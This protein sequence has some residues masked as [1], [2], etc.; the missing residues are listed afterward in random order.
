MAAGTTGNVA[1]AEDAPVG[2]I[3]EPAE[4]LKAVGYAADEIPTHEEFNWTMQ[5][6]GRAS[7]R[8]FATSEDLIAARRAGP[9]AIPE[10]VGIVLPGG[11]YSGSVQPWSVAWAIA[12]DAN[13]T[14]MCCD[15]EYLW[16]TAGAGIAKFIRR[17]LRST[18]AIDLD[19]PAGTFDYPFLA[20]AGGKV[21]VCDDVAG[22]P[23]LQ[24]YNRTDLTL[25]YSLALPAAATVYAIATDG[26]FVGVAAG[27]FLRLY[28]DTGAALALVGS[29]DHTA[30]V[31]SVAM[32]GHFIV[33]GGVTPGGGPP[34]N[35]IRFLDYTPALSDSR[36]RT[37]NPAV[38]KVCFDGEAVGFAG[39]IDGA[40]YTGYFR[41]RLA[42]IRWEEA[43]AAEDCLF[44]DGRLILAK[45]GSI[46]IHDPF[47]GDRID[48][49][50][51]DAG[52]ATNVH[53]LAHDFDGFF[54]LGDATAGG[55]RLRRYH[56]TN[57]PRLY[58]VQEPGYVTS[59]YYRAV[60]SLIQPVEQRNVR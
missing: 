60:H 29:Y 9:I 47:N 7:I 23:T 15:G 40:N 30:Q 32:D 38:L 21:Y 13:E 6:L 4:A 41:S 37:G 59:V 28:R 34:H 25:A 17:R 53:R 19:Q 22:T 16:V 57:Q 39:D 5:R 54:A 8:R 1:W 45:D 33:I 48:V 51:W 14:E 43:A 56:I 24:A 50:I 31:N 2:D 49:L 20:T 3:S 26:Y 55:F 10:D 36:S 58:A 11:T 12:G 42:T 27:N 18:G 52:A 46:S 44:L 35:Q